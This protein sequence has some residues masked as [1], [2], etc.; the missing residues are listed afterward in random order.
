MLL[1]QP[2]EIDRNLPAWARRSNPIIRR[3]L[4]MYWKTVLPE[5]GFVI[6]VLVLQIIFVVVTL[7]IPFLFNL[8]MPTITASL[9]LFPFALYIYGQALFSVG[10]NA[11]TAIVHEI[12]SDT[13]TLL[14]VTPLDLESIVAS[15]IAASIWRQ[16]EN[17]SILIFAASLFSLPLLISQ[18]AT[19]WP[20][21]S[22][23]YISRVAMIIGLVVSLARL[24]LEPV[25]IAT[26][27]AMIGA[28]VP[29]RS[30]ALLSTTFFGFFY[31]LLMNMSRVVQMSWP[32][33]YLVEFVLPI[34]VPLL[35][36]A[37]AFRLTV[38]FLQR[39]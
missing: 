26:V 6:R 37:G 13:F 12:R 25:M 35:L 38:Y 17:L 4:G 27:G 23:P 18:Y 30:T 34:A 22:H 14:R 8:A 19:L 36:T 33:H 9:L 2:I 1:E 20:M 29:V 15:K 21:D 5:A 32:L 31:F 16:A 3:Q 10:T 28:A 24:F 11:V 7:P 39:D